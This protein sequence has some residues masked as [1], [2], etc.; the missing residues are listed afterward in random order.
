MGGG[1]GKHYKTRAVL[2]HGVGVRWLSGVC[3]PQHVLALPWITVFSLWV[4]I[5][6]AVLWPHKASLTS[7]QQLSSG[8]LDLWTLGI[9][10]PHALEEM[11]RN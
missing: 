7:T 6:L 3:R 1:Q 11:V 10:E 4:H 9:C 2:G 8:L 5:P